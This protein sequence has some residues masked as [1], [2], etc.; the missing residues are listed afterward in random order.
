VTVWSIFPAKQNLAS[1]KKDDG[2]SK[3]AVIAQRVAP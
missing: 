1:S 2:F 3:S